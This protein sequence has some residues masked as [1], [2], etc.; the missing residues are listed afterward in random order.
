MD[1]TILLVRQCYL[2]VG[3]DFRLEF[4]AESFPECDLF[5]ASREPGAACASE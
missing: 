3:S 5:P 2:F 4:S 1:T